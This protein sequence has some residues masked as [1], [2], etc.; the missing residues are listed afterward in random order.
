MLVLL[1]AAA[2]PLF[3]QVRIGPVV[4]GAITRWNPEKNDD[5]PFYSSDYRSGYQTGIA[6][7]YWVNNRFSL[8]TEW[9][10]MYRQKD[11]TYQRNLI[12]VQDV[13]KHNYLAV[14][15]LFRVSF[16]TDIKKSHQE[17]YVNAG[18]ALH[19]WLG[20]SGRIK[21]NEQSPYVEGGVMDYTV[22]FQEPGEYGASEYI[23]PAHR[24]QMSLYA[25]GGVIFD[26]GFSHHIWLDARSSLG[27]ARSFFASDA[28][29]DFGLQLYQD[30][31]RSAIDSW[32]LSVGYFHDINM[33]AVLKKGKVSK[34]KK[35]N[36]KLRKNYRN[37]KTSS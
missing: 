28:K 32:T 33:T 20:G 21:T 18:P 10:Y 19:Y 3:A 30:N 12:Q 5:S 11:V 8:H 26:L 29:G 23:T 24:W 31:L 36:K 16:H 2:S 1:C 13:A 27:L 22:R 7:N 9:L 35:K 6:A 37:G 34:K 15:A 14:P 4:G 25:G 17:W